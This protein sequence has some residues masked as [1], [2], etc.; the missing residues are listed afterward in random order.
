M[1]I[2]DIIFISA[3]GP[4][5]GGKSVITPRLQRHFNIITYTNLGTESVSMIFSKI[6]SAFV[7]GFSEKVRGCIAG[8]VESSQIV[9]QAVADN[10]KP[11]PSKIHYTFNL[12]DISKIVQGVCA[13]DQKL[14]QE[15][16]DIY[17]IW[18]HENLRV[19]G[20]RMIN[21]D[22]K[23]ILLDL[24]ITECAKAKLKKEDIFNV[25]RIIY[26]DYFNG[27]DG[28]NR[29]YIQITDTTGI[30]G[31]MDIYLEEFNSGSKHPMKLVM[32]LDACDHVSRIC[33][34]LRQP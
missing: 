20:D 29:P 28:E 26:G 23:A 10:L 6:L 13:S 22:D 33:R 15:E 4:P 8:I 9:F 31:K 2:E 18:V 17:R 27:I 34:V 24:L 14:T 7:G 21:E 25:E 19:F 30:L 1:R 12:R 11:T 16:V 3:M 5:G 32:F